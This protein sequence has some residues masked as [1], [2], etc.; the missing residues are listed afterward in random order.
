MFLVDT[1]VLV[2][3]A[4][5]SAPEHA[6]CRA[7]LERWR[8]EP[9]PWYLTWPIVYE[10]LRV[11][12]H[13]RV[14]RAPMSLGEAWAFVGA[15]LAS[16]SLTVVGPSPQHA[17]VAGRTFEEI[18]SLRG[19]LLHDAHTATLMREHG[20]RTIVTRDTD[21]HRFPFLD[22]LDPLKLAP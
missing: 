15:L 9:L 7:L 19:N 4:D 20:I 6:Q 18:P 11:S 16:P 22:P 5:R 8:V 3:A 1:N 2:Y 10:F 14:F 21:F 17:Q 12:T 13:P